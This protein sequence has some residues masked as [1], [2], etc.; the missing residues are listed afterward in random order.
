M[1][2]FE[3]LKDS[4]HKEIQ[5]AKTLDALKVLSKHVLA[6]QSPLTMALSLI[7][8]LEG[9]EKK[10]QGDYLNHLKVSFLKAVEDKKIEIENMSWKEKID[11]ETL[12]VTCPMVNPDDLGHGHP[13]VQFMSEV[14][15]WFQSQGFS[16]RSGPEVETE[17]YNFDALNVHKDHPA[18]AEHDT[19]YVDQAL[20]RTH[21]SPVQIRTLLEEKPPVRIVSAGRVYRADSDR[22]H[23][24]MFH[25]IEGLVIEDGIHLG[26]LKGCLINF[27]SY[28]F[29][30]PVELRFRPSYFPFTN[31]SMEVDIA[32]SVKKDH[33]DI[34]Q[35]D[36]WLEVGG[37]GM[38][39]PHVLSFCDID[40]AV[41]QGFAFGMGVERMVM[42][43]YGIKDL[44]LFYHNDQ[45]WLRQNSHGSLA[46]GL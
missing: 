16:L 7:H 1:Q 14:L 11:Q 19:F 15:L 3:V 10:Q 43:K 34:G 31:L 23:A 29:E 13:I 30:K 37:C 42:L 5:E 28:V 41:H 32:Y 17:T 46:L 45:R 12:D 18:R 20:L 33:L 9:E 26:H 8:T 6:K 36:L 4:W 2:N 38:V 22:T 25:Q 40:P 35:G 24:P 21:T 27:F 44:R 39:H